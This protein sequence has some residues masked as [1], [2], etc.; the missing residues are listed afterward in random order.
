MLVDEIV[1]RTRRIVGGSGTL[2][3]R[4][5]AVADLVRDARGYRWVGIYSVRGDRVVN[6]TFSG[7]GAPAYPEFDV[8]KGLTGVAIREERTVV[9][10]DVANDPRYLTAFDSTGSEVI[11]PITL[12]DRVVGTLDVES[13]RTNAFSE[14]DLET[15]ERVAAAMVPLWRDTPG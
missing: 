7:P 5:R 14:T 8:S 4:C 15:L 10:N 2:T 12:G 11:V 1:E 9:S 13:E 6:E 3:D